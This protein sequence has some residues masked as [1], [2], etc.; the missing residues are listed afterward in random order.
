MTNKLAIPLLAAL[1][2]LLPLIAYA[3]AVFPAR[4]GPTAQAAAGC[5]DAPRQA[6]VPLPEPGAACL[7]ALGA[8]GAVLRRWRR[9]GTAA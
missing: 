3:D 1:L 4:P 6:E 9:G 8:G 2:L 5:G 7:V